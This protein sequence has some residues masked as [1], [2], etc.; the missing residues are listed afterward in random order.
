MYEIHWLATFPSRI[1]NTLMYGRGLRDASYSQAAGGQP[2]VSSQEGLGLPMCST[3]SRVH[4]GE[5][6]R[7]RQPALGHVLGDPFLRHPAQVEY[8]WRGTLLSPRP[9]PLRLWSRLSIIMVV[10]RHNLG[11]PH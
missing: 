10:S 8:S 6:R 11:R 9:R 1:S 5:L 7:F 4:Q 3:P 2:A